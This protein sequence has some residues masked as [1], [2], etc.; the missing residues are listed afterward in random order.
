MMRTAPDC[1]EQE[2][3]CYLFAVLLGAFGVGYLTS[4]V[5]EGVSSKAVELVANE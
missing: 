4:Q 1:A 3:V 5:P 2:S